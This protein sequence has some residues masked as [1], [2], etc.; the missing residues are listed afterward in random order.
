MTASRTSPESILIV[1]L[2]S[3]GDVVFALPA[4]EQLRR[5]FPS[6]RIGWAVEDRAAD[7]LVGHPAIDE[8]IIMPRR[9]W[10]RLRAE[11][12]SRWRVWKEMRA[13]GRALRD[14][15]FDVAID[16]QGNLKSGLVT[17]TSGAK[18]RIGHARSEGREPN[19]W[20]TNRRVSFGGRVM[21]RIERDLE[22]LSALDVPTEF[23]WPR[24][25]FKADDR[26]IVDAF[27]SDLPG[28]GPLIVMNPGT[29]DWSPNKRWPAGHWAALVDALVARRPGLRLVLNWGP[30]EEPLL[31]AIE[32][33]AH[34]PI[35]RPPL[36]KNMRE[37]GHLMNQADLVIGCDTGPVHLAAALQRN[38]VALFG[39]TD[40]RLYYPYRHPERALYESIPCSPCRYRACPAV[41]CMRLISPARVLEVAEAALD[42]RVIAPGRLAPRKTVKA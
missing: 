19:W 13:F 32:L 18:L 35:A 12:T 1:R 28:N 7:L 17:R 42:G 16:F 36:L 33:A 30:G 10:R 39:P 25:A 22:L 6:A 31:D 40:P 38:V 20:F 14:H 4:L 21:H 3:V 8:L 9:R 29:S 5:A 34:A 37:V 27:L 41:D 2:S 24:L 15:R 23:H 26:R 11:G